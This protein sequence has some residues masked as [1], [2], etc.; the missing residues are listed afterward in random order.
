MKLSILLK[1][2][3]E[4]RRVI[5]AGEGMDH[6]H[7]VKTGQYDNLCACLPDYEIGS[8]HYRAQEVKHNGLFVAVKGFKA[9]GHNFI[10]EALTRGASTIVT[11]KSI[12]KKP[13]NK[14]FRNYR[15]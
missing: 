8:I 4:I 3:T 14:E 2:V 12:N 13:V 7:T 11:R 15:G 1:S 6:K 5:I 10:D 9:D